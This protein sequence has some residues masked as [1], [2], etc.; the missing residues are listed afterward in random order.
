MPDRT[1]SCAGK[2]RMV[3]REGPIQQS[4]SD[5]TVSARQRHERSQPDQFQSPH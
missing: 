2:I 4:D 1:N 3:D 5:L